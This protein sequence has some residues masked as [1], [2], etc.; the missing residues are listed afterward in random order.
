MPGDTV[1]VDETTLPFRG[2][3]PFRQYN[4]SKAN[5]YGIKLYKAC[6][7]NGSTW[8]VD[9]YCGKNENIVEN[10]DHPGDTVVKLTNNLLNDGRLTVTDNWYTSIALAEYLYRKRTN[11]LGT[12]RKN[13]RGLLTEVL[14]QNLRKGEICSRQNEYIT[15]MKKKDQR[16]VYLLAT[17]FGDSME[18]VGEDR[19]ANVQVKDS[20]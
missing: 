12:I 17:C 11:F 4:P 3:L 9:V 7:P 19:A 1:V 5:A 16:D 18:N 15:Y 13:R 20:D 8:N 6:T 2:R 10:L 14:H